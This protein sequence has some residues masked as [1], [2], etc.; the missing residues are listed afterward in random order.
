MRTKNRKGRSPQRDQ[1]ITGRRWMELRERM[2]KINPLCVHCMAEGR[3]KVWTQLDHIVPLVKGGTNEDRNLQGLCD[4]CHDI[5]THKDLGYKVK[6]RIG[7][8]GFPIELKVNDLGD[9]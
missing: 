5:K 6:R 9:T 2:F 8:D 4:N 3:I 7:V 1:R